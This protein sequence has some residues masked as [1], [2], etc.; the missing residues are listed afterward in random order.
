[1]K[2]NKLKFLIVI[3]VT[4][5]LCGC[6]QALKDKDNKIIVNEKTGQS[7][8][9]NV[10]CRPTDKEVLAKYE[11]NEV[12]LSKLPECE[13]ME[14][15]GEYEGIWTN[16]FVRPLVRPLAYVIVKIGNFVKSYG[17]S[18]IIM[19]ILIRVALYPITRKTASQS[20]KMK[21]AQPELARLEEKYKDKT[22]QEE[23]MQKSQEMMA[24]YK[25]YNINPVSGCLFAFL[26]LPIFFAF[27]EAINRVPAI[28]EENFL[29]IFQMGTT[30]WVGITGGNYVYIVLNVLIAAATFFSFNNTT[31]DTAAMGNQKQTKM[32]TI[33]MTVFIIFM[34]FKLPAAVAIYWIISSCFTI[35][36]NILV[37]RGKKKDDRKA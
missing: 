9:E 21:D 6:T 5:I 30:P 34:S 32:M 25:K 4:F 24:V 10:M 26:Q 31:K 28:F 12:D 20:E 22:S 16:I 1:M 36:Q 13:D 18:L 35:L 14:V 11:E 15:W 19:T 23:Q 3:L 29:G 33:F 17:L 37:K 27:L 2:K 7:I 8:T